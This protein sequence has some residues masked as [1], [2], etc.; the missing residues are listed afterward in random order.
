MCGLRQSQWKP[1]VSVG[2][3][4]LLQ[5]EKFVLSTYIVSHHSF[6]CNIVFLS[7]SAVSL[8]TTLKLVFLCPFTKGYAYRGVRS[9]NFF[10]PKPD[11][12]KIK[13]T[14]KTC[15]YLIAQN[16]G[17][18]VFIILV[19]QMLFE[20]D[21]CMQS[22]KI[23]NMLFTKNNQSENTSHILAASFPYLLYPNLLLLRLKL[24]GVLM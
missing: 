17:L 6:C 12:C 11:I 22:C 14:Q 24:G 19:M 3:A 8:F 2:F 4:L 18:D 1:A 13:D 9:S 16:R 7:K 21:F 15:H 20:T 23:T 5:P 10:L